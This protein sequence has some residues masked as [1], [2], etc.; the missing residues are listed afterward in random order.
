MMKTMIMI[1]MMMETRGERCGARVACTRDDNIKINGN[2]KNIGGNTIIRIVTQ[3]QRSWDKLE[4]KHCRDYQGP[5]G[6]GRVRS[7]GFR[8]E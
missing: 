7:S 2:G 4:N 6:P 5:G 1:M 8:G 3:P